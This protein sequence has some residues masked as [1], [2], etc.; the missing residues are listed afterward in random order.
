MSVSATS[1][2]FCM[3]ACSALT[4]LT[5]WGTPPWCTTRRITSPSRLCFTSHATNRFAS[6]E[7]D[8]DMKAKKPLSFHHQW[9]AQIRCDFRASVCPSLLQGKKSWRQEVGFSQCIQ[10]NST[11][12]ITNQGITGTSYFFCPISHR[13]RSILCLEPCKGGESM[14]AHLDT[15]SVTSRRKTIGLGTNQRNFTQICSA[16]ASC[17]NWA[18]EHWVSL[19]CVFFHRW[20][21]EGTDVINKKKQAL[22]FLT[23]DP[24]VIFHWAPLHQTRHELLV[25][26]QRFSSLLCGMKE[27]IKS[28][29]NQLIAQGPN[30][31]NWQE[32]F[33]FLPCA[34]C[35]MGVHQNV[36]TSVVWKAFPRYRLSHRF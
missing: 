24:G 5:R 11:L 15:G 25:T 8:E 2:S 22:L 19:Q 14:S 27:C 18:K 3:T 12:A 32:R 9:S 16:S 13:M 31:T 20:L 23:F 21:S 36:P 17:V 26:S 33:V 34:T 1:A 29:R 35:H 4:M 10:Q 7:T 30:W 6:P 28:C